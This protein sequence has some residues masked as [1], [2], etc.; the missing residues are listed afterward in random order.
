MNTLPIRKLYAYIILIFA[1][2]FSNSL[3]R[4]VWAENL[5]YLQT[6]GQLHTQLNWNIEKQNDATT[7]LTVTNNSNGT[8]YTSKN[9]VY[10]EVI[11]WHLKNPLAKTELTAWRQKNLI[12]VKG[13][14]NGKSF[15]KTLSIDT[16]PWFQPMSF[17]LA[18]FVQSE[19][20]AITFWTLN[21]DNLKAFKMRATKVTTET[22]RINR[23]EALAQKVKVSLTG[24]R[25]TIWQAHYW[26]S[27]KDGTFLKYEGI[28]GPPGTPLT[29]TTLMG[30]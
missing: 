29:V 20:L 22:L 9:N 19:S 17:S 16:D 5:T 27:T 18:Q 25:A 4:E 12:F 30:I 28:D 1:I 10:L 11:Q 24:L 21:P 8:I 3:T 7:E 13:T 2:I 15:K 6:T 26:F 23:K 14:L